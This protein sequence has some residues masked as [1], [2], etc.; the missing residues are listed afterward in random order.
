M[1][2]NSTVLRVAINGFGRIG[3]TAFRV[4]VNNPRIRVVAINDLGDLT[5]MA[6]LLRFDSIYGRFMHRVEAK[7]GQLIVDG[8]PIDF[9][10]EKDPTKLPWKKLNIDVV[11]ECTGRFVSDGGAQVHIDAGAKRVVVSAP[12]KGGGIDTF[13]LGVNADQYR[14]QNV[15]SNSSCTTNCVAPVTRVIQK[16]FGITK[17]TMTT[18][19]SYTAEQNL[20]DGPVPPL[21]P[22]LRRARAAALNI[23]PT[24]SGAAISTTETIPELK[25]LFDGYALRVPTPVVSFTDFTFLVAKRTTVEAVNAAF[26]K[27]A[28]DPA[29]AHILAVTEDPV[30]STDLKGDPHSATIDL[31]LTKVIDGD[32]VKVAAWYDNE[33]GYS[34]RL[35]ELAE[36]LGRGVS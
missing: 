24:T 19:H 22:D 20:V 16:A 1:K 25:G 35:V 12:T 36:S 10:A 31:G 13:I 33:W 23:V 15:V 26:R 11:L 14:N 17:A 27:A 7:P 34:N 8:S 29:L 3:R 5:I 2:K 30:V 4:A 18:V 28:A 21:H 32:L 6:H 9:L